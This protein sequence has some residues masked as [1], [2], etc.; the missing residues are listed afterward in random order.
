MTLM[1]GRSLWTKHQQRH[2]EYSVYLQND[3]ERTSFGFVFYC[4]AHC[5][6]FLLLISLSV[7][8][9]LPIRR[10]TTLANAFFLM[11]QSSTGILAGIHILVGNV[12]LFHE[13]L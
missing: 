11:L 3:L 12:I 8:R 7:R 5:S 1:F 4:S 2:T 6:V 9:C 13:I 10:M